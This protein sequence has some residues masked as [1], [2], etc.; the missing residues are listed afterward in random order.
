MPNPLRFALSVIDRQDGATAVEYALMIA[1]IALAIVSAVTVLG[2]V[3]PGW[4]QPAAN[5]LA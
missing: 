3:L 4:F 5:G 1:L 2:L